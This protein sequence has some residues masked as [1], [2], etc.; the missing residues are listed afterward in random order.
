M[1][2]ELISFKSGQPNFKKCKDKL[3]LYSTVP[4][5]KAFILFYVTGSSHIL[6]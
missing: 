4:Q 6:Y 3:P 5:V 2:R 1:G